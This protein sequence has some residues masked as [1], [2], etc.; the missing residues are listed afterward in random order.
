MW[1][2]FMVPCPTPDGR[3]AEVAV[4]LAGDVGLVP[5]P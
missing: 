3:T 4:R 2:L 1:V 5:E